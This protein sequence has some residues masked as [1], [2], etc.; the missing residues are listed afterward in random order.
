ME[1]SMPSVP[2]GQ[3][4]VRRFWPAEP[5]APSMDWQLGY[6]VLL[7]LWG[8]AWLVGLLALMLFFHRAI[9]AENGRTVAEGARPAA[10]AVEHPPNTETDASL[11]QTSR[12]RAVTSG[13][14]S[15]T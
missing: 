11:D 9:V 8:L 5:D 12:P 7:I 3:S 14:A 6:D 13:S 15:P 4:L 10:L 2:T 1:L